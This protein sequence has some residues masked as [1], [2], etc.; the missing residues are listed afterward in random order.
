MCH[1]SLCASQWRSS[2]CCADFACPLRPRTVCSRLAATPLL[3]SP[4]LCW[5]C[6]LLV[7]FATMFIEEN[8]THKLTLCQR[9]QCRPCA[10][11]LE[12]C[13]C[14]TRGA[15]TGRYCARGAASGWRVGTTATSTR[16]VRATGSD[17]GTL[18][19]IYFAQA[20]APRY[21]ASLLIRVSE[22]ANSC[23]RRR[24]TR[25]AIGEH[26]MVVLAELASR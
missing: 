3:L 26:V 12:P 1:A 4:L 13:V 6:A 5:C 17:K 7:V 23:V 18:R 14:H 22:S 8:R 11:H 24:R 20:P 21:G 9:G 2:S 10:A 19:V 15:Q 16:G 25:F